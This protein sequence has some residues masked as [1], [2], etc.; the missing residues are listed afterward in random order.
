MKSSNIKTLRLKHIRYSPF[1]SQICYPREDRERS[2]ASDDATCMLLYVKRLFRS[3]LLLPRS[4]AL[5]P[6]RLLF[7]VLL[8]PFWIIVQVDLWVTLD[9]EASH[10]SYNYPS[11]C[12][13]TIVVLAVLSQSQFF[14]GSGWF[15]RRIHLAI[16]VNLKLIKTVIIN[17]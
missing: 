15:L 13:Y 14:D 16:F 8:F 9:S 12:C 4:L 6:I 11:N 3:F 10:L 7:H 17:V 2:K 5:L 1:V